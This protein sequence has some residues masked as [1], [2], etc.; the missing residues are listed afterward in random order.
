MTTFRLIG[1]A[2]IGSALLLARSEERLAISA[3]SSCGQGNPQRLGGEISVET[4]RMFLKNLTAGY[5]A[6]LPVSHGRDPFE[7]TPGVQGFEGMYLGVRQRFPQESITPFV[8]VSMLGHLLAE[9]PYASL[10]PE[11]GIAIK[12][13]KQYELSA[14]VRYFLTSRGR[15]NDFLTFGLGVSRIF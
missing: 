9:R 2:L 6:L 4:D 15:D 1:L 11:V 3:L 8:G 10:N 13:L 12:V 7:L 5:L 14:H